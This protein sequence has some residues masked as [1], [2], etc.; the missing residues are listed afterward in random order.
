[1]VDKKNNGSFNVIMIVA[2]F[3]LLGVMRPLL[4]RIFPEISGSK[5]DSM[6]A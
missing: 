2:I 1:M 5:E 4:A 3:G 6:A